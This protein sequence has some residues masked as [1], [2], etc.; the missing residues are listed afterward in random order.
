MHFV[1]C[2]QY[3]ARI[4]AGKEVV[5]VRHNYRQRREVRRSEI[6]KA[7]VHRCGVSTGLFQVNS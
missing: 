2:M 7:P 3:A 1:Y 6:G 5:G 4:Y